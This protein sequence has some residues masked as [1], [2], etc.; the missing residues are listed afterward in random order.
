MVRKNVV[1]GIVTALVLL[2]S[3]GCEDTKSPTAPIP[4]E[5]GITV[6]TQLDIV[7]DFKLWDKNSIGGEVTI[8]NQNKDNDEALVDIVHVE[9][10]EAACIQEWWNWSER[11]YHGTVAQ[12]QTITI[13]APNLSYGDTMQIT[14]K[15]S[16]VN[17]GISFDGLL[18]ID[19]TPEIE[20]CK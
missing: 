17:W 2:T 7:F 15:I 6:S 19:D 10:V 4:E 18:V 11:I 14:I 12:N 1:I 3:F 5:W 8:H 16:G 13:E 9:S 20:W